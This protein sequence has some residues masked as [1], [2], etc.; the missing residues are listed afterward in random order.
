MAAIDRVAR[1]FPG[2]PG[3]ETAGELQAVLRAERE[4]EPFLLVRGPGGDL[5]ILKVSPEAGS[6]TIGRSPAADLSIGWDG[7]VSALHAE[8]KQLAGE[9]TLVDDGLSR[10][11][12]YVNGERIR[13]RQRLRTRDVLCFGTTLVQV[14]IPGDA[15]RTETRASGD[16]SMT[17]V[18]SAQQRKVLTAL[19]RPVVGGDSL[20]APATNQQI[21]DELSLSVAAVKL[22]LRAL[23][24]KFQIGEL[25]Q[26]RKRLALARRALLTS[27]V[28]PD[29]QQARV[30][31]T[32][33]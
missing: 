21:A 1:A 12:S 5:R 19:C 7:Q 29:A 33:P 32:S 14:R 24:E 11:G 13:G 2:A 3:A 20:A 26:N 17:P 25:P 4:G 16:A 27:S 18:L 31:T 6:L 10:N 22:H 15:G 28:M 9:L 30:T 23:F 8:L